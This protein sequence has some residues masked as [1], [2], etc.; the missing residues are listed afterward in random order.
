MILIIYLLV[1]DLVSLSS[2]VGQT[3]IIDVPIT[4]IGPILT[5]I[6]QNCKIPVIKQSTNSI[7]YTLFKKTGE[8]FFMNAEVQIF[9]DINVHRN[10]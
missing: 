1:C 4:T 9:I 3:Y 2:T 7:T 6:S 8:P 10:F 5:N